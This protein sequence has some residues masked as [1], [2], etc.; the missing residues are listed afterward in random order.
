MLQF[1]LTSTGTPVSSACYSKGDA[2]VTN[3][4]NVPAVMKT[5]CLLL[6]SETGN[7]L[8][9]TVFMILLGC[10]YRMLKITE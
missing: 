1:S 4:N 6:C 10:C 3:S 5:A 9:N 8:F 7:M 2:S